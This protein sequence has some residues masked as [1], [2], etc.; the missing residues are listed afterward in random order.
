MLFRQTFL[1]NRLFGWR[2]LPVVLFPRKGHI[3]VFDVIVLL[4]RQLGTSFYDHFVS[5]YAVV[6][7]IMDELIYMSVKKKFIFFVKMLGTDS[8]CDCFV[9]EPVADHSA[10]ELVPWAGNFDH[11]RAGRGQQIPQT[12]HFYYI[13]LVNLIISN[14]ASYQICDNQI[15]CFN[16]MLFFIWYSFIV[17]VFA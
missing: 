6:H 14:L 10:E 8:Y 3:D 2:A 13:L 16:V 9:Y 12:T 5:W 7:L 17:L 11:S 1:F 15:H 4:F